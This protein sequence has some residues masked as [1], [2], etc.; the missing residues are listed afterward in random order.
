M[1]RARTFFAT[2]ILIGLTACRVE[3]YDGLSQRDANEMTA[4]LLSENIDARRIEEKGGT[5]GVEVAEKEFAQAV[6]LISDS[7]LPRPQFQS[8]DKIFET[9]NLVSSPAEERA[10]IAYAMS[11][12]LSRTVSEI[13]GVVSARVH[14]SAPSLD[15]LGRK[16]T[17]SS[18]SVALHHDTRLD[19][20]G[21]VPRI[22]LLVSHA[23][24][25]LNYDNVL[26]ALFPVDRSNSSSSMNR[27]PAPQ[28]A[29]ARAAATGSGI[30]DEMAW[31]DGFGA[32]ERG[33]SAV[34]ST[35]SPFEASIN[36]AVAVTIGGGLLVLF[37]AGRTLFGR[38]RQKVAVRSRSRDDLYDDDG[39]S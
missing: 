27:R 4:L 9:D 10:R 33:A 6:Q 13:D 28:A 15:P 24:D 36:P 1:F 35:S 38:P 31:P 29:P 20:D 2:A 22:K 11:Q 17:E 5:F 7:G 34:G 32:S 8:M 14:L 23:V 39:L 16:T 12:E 30:A 18:A 3:V 37:L 19:T 26:V 25:D 21:L